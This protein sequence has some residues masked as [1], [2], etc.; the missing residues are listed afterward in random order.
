MM[1]SRARCAADDGYTLG[2]C[3]VALFVIGMTMAGL[4]AGMASLGRM[5]TRALQTT[6]AARDL[7][8]VHEDL[9]RFLQGQGPFASPGS[10]VFTGTS[11]GFQF[12]CGVADDCRAWVT[13]APGGMALHL[14]SLQG[15]TI[16]PLKGV[17]SAQFVYAGTRTI[18]PVWPAEAAAQPLKS[19]GLLA[20]TPAGVVP[21]ADVALVI[22][23]GPYCD[24]DAILK[25]CRR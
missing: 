16:V 9:D 2:E 18:G 3:L 25:D 24:F 12:R 20:Q 21:L 4:S 6:A 10:D 19:I 15:Q 5:Q 7:R 22:D 13:G 23:Q 11:S 14:V 8:A 1:L 17:R